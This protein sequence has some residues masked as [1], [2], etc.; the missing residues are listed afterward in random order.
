MTV[1]A[2]IRLPG[3]TD[4]ANDLLN[5]LLGQL[6]DKERFNRTVAAFYDA[7]QRM[8][9]RHNGII[10]AEYYNLGLVLG[11]AQKGVDA[12]ARRCKLV[13]LDWADGDLDS[14]GYKEFADS[15]HLAAEANQGVTSSLIHAV[16][17]AVASR[18]GE[19][20]PGAMV[21]FASAADATG[22][23]NPRKRGLD[24]FV[25]V[26]DRDDQGPSALTFYLDGR[27]ITATKEQGKWDTDVSEHTFGVPAAPMAYKPRLG[28]PFGRSRISRPVR[29]LQRAAIRELVRLEG[30]MDVYSRPE[31][32]LLGA[33]E[34][35]F[36]QDDGANTW[37]T[38][39]GKVRGIPDDQ[40][41]LSNSDA[42]QLARADVKQFPAS[43]PAPHLAALNMYSKL[44]ARE[45]SLPDSSVAIT[46]FSNPTSGEAYDSSQYELISEAEGVTDEF[47]PGLEYVN[48]IALAM[49]NN[50]SSVP[51]EWA[52]LKAR[53]VDPRYQSRAAQADAGAKAIGAVP[54]LA[55][56]TVGLELLGLNPDQV[57]R[58]Q[59]ELR[60][61]R[62]STALGTL[63]PVTVDES[64]NTPAEGAQGAPEGAPGGE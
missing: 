27:T 16:S 33:G 64:P 20:E 19:G 51:E 14:L 60:R 5:G 31:F 32:I 3:L 15:N 46:D 22:E 29:G 56:T 10:P 59:G 50:E 43:D 57:A 35:V 40:E 18:G 58:A 63:R 7:E 9:A 53:W 48:R 38:G 13:G 45:L 42:P 8:R 37:N 44:V 25:W 41:V 4:D 49:L 61:N 26:A 34:D 2:K 54:A 6:A 62:L 52:T 24:A 30:H 47:S 12:L 21:H 36:D 39:L 1:N 55:E 23:W 11:W 17:F 28:R